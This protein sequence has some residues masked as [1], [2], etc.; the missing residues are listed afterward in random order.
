MPSLKTKYLKSLL[1]RVAPHFFVMLRLGVHGIHDHEGEVSVV[2]L[3]LERPDLGLEL[4]NQGLHALM[5][6][7]ILIRGKGKLLDVA[8]RLAEVFQSV[9]ET[10]V[11]SFNF[12]FKKLVIF[13]TFNFRSFL[14]SYS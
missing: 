5:V 7:P 10:S 6:L 11:L 2:D 12:V 13:W 3:L 8:L 4:V 1:H 14:V 9:S